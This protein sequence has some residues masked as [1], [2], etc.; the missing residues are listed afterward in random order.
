M[1]TVEGAGRIEFLEFETDIWVTDVFAEKRGSGMKLAREF[2][3]YARRA[4]KNIYG[5]A[6]PKDNVTQMDFDRLLRWY[7]LLG[8]K[9]APMAGNPFAMKLEI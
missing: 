5:E 7:R 6:K 2:I 3:R 8:G 1:L 9:P 4:R